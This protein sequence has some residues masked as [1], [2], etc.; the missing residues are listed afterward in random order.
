MC[1]QGDDDATVAN[2]PEAFWDEA[3]EDS[4]MKETIKTKLSFGQPIDVKF[5]KKHAPKSV[6]IEVLVAEF[7]NLEMYAAFDIILDL[8][9]HL[10]PA[11]V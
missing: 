3:T 11:L 4:L 1:L 2:D 6:P 9:T 7:R 10:A 5:V 8:L